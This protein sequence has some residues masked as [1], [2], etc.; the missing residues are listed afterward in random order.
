MNSL[1]GLGGLGRSEEDAH[2]V[3]GFAG[4][5]AAGTVIKNCRNKFVDDA[6]VLKL[7]SQLIFVGQLMIRIFLYD[8]SVLLLDDQAVIR[9][10]IELDYAI[11]A[12]DKGGIVFLSVVGPADV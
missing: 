6:G 7:S 1:S 9:I 4:V 2:G 10:G 12:V 3:N 11:G 8:G 5:Q